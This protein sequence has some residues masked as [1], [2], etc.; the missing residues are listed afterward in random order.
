VAEKALLDRETLSELLNEIGKRLGGRAE[1]ATLYVF[2]GARGRGA[3]GHGR[4]NS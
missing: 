4:M 2:G 1:Q 3:D